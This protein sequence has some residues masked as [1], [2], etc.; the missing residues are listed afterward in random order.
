MNWVGLLAGF[1]YWGHPMGEMTRSEG[2]G[3]VSKELGTVM[4]LHHGP[5]RTI[6]LSHSYVFHGKNIMK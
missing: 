3:Q 2:R 4:I 6:P 5:G 1:Q